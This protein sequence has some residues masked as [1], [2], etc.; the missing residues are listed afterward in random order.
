TLF[1][2]LTD[3]AGSPLKEPATPFNGT[4]PSKESVLNNTPDNNI[5]FN[6]FEN[7]LF[8]IANRTT[9]NY[10]LPNDNPDPQ[11]PCINCGKVGL[12][13]VG[14]AG[15]K[16][17][18]DLRISSVKC[19]DTVRCGRSTR[20]HFA[21][22]KYDESLLAAYNRAYTHIVNINRESANQQRHS[23][24]SPTPSPPSQPT[25]TSP[26][27]PP[28]V[29]PVKRKANSPP[30]QRK[31]QSQQNQGDLD[32]P[33]LEQ[34]SEIQI[35]KPPQFITSSTSITSSTQ[36][37]RK[38]QLSTHTQE[39]TTTRS[40]T[41]QQHP[42]TEDQKP[43]TP[44]K[45]QQNQQHQSNN[46]KMPPPNTVTTA[47]FEALTALV[48]KLSER[49]DVV[50]DINKK[51]EQN[52]NKAMKKMQDLVKEYTEE[53]QE[54]IQ[55]QN[56]KINKIQQEFKELATI[57]TKTSEEANNRA[58]N[59]ENMLKE[60]TAKTAAK[61]NEPWPALQQSGQQ[62]QTLITSLQAI[63]NKQQ[64]TQE[65]ESIL[66]L[67]TPI[68]E[69]IPMN[70]PESIYFRIGRCEPTETAA[71]RKDRIRRVFAHEFGIQTGI[72]NVSLLGRSVAHVYVNEN[73]AKE[74]KIQLK[75]RGR[76]LENYNPLLAT[77][78]VTA[79]QAREFC[80]NRVAYMCA[81]TDNMEKREGLMRGFPEDVVNEIKN[82]TEQIRTQRN[83]FI[84]DLRAATR[85]PPKAASN[86]METD[87]DLDY[88]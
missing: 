75:K 76:L 24:T 81:N 77:T 29:T 4:R 68:H 21:L 20:L 58:V 69:R 44:T 14:R 52:S 42:T 72:H 39:T 8:N 17:A 2:F 59:M 43:A 88:E 13:F 40:T 36:Q 15:N 79:K 9:A 28:P 37:P 30:Q 27:S 38:K 63:K 83:S 26:P 10:Q 12:L 1:S 65:Q 7:H 57:L 56:E 85:P 33:V 22:E 34:F 48:N 51:A 60:L 54:M 35:S 73:E 23:T 5:D 32:N 11:L 49:I 6:K 61:T 66:T 18:G 82:L 3:T 62:K 87:N 67:G 46:N 86:S 55:K 71:A 41:T 70:N 47:Q 84:G 25:N 19:P 31:R 74:L 16:L 64:L 78:T 80:V 50:E 53:H 45:Q